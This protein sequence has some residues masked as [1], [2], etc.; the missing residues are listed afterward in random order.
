MNNAIEL[1]TAK[2]AL[3]RMWLIRLFEER[4]K[5]RYQQNRVAGCFMGAL[6]SYIGQEAVAV[7][8]S[9]N[10]RDDDYVFSTHRGHGHLIAKGG[11]LKAIM[12]ELQG[13]ATGCSHGMGG[14]MHLFDP[15]LAFMGG[16]GIVGGGL[17]LATGAAYAAQYRHTTQV[18]VCY[19][20][21]G[22]AS[23][24]TFHEALNMAGLWKLPV[25]FV[26]ENNNYAVLTPACDTIA[27]KD[28]AMRAAGYAMPGIVLD[29]NDLE[30][31]YSAAGGAVRRA[32]AGEGPSLLE[33]KTFRHDSH[34]MVLPEMRPADEITHWKTMDPIKRY[35]IHLANDRQVSGEDLA[36]IKLEAVN[37]IEAADQFAAK[38]D[39]PDADSFRAN[40]SR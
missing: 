22:A 18:A 35:E 21:D 6:H 7:G 32:R 13:K 5:Q 4:A 19:F 23:Q 8:I 27:V 29:G 28:V 3:K 24:G 38:S 15:K 14:S 37:L 1:N 17:P 20:G 31:I 39:F 40:V 2:E 9:L 26:C 30:A 11:D 10:L 25:I 34:C 33:C 12:A 36:A 16:N